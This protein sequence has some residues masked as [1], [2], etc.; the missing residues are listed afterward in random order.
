M[1][2]FFKSEDY[3]LDTSNF[4]S[5]LHDRVVGVFEEEIASYVGAKYACTVNSATSAIFLIFLNKNTEVSVPSMIPPVVLNAL[6]TSGNKIKFYDDTDWVGN[7]YILHT[8]S[9]FKVVDSAQK[10]DKNQFKKE[11]N[12]QDLMF[13][14]H[15]PTKPVGSC[16]GGTIVSDDYEKIQ[17]LKEFTMNGMSFSHNNWEREI[18]FPGFK[19]YMNSLQADIALR[20][21]KSLEKNNEKIRKIRELY[22]YEL[23]ISNI[24]NHLYR[25]DVNDNQRF[26]KKMHGEGLVC[27][28]HYKAQHENDIYVRYSKKFD[29]DDL[30]KSKLKSKTT[31]S[32]PFYPDLSE[33]QQYK[34]IEKIK[35]YNNEFPIQNI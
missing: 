31:A 33:A 13:F 23:G 5:L 11:C 1:I 28:I 4:S 12:P 25:I 2:P 20:N 9:N 21:L 30:K 27:G 15:Y 8:F 26:I 18:K 6:I 24:S 29:P 16:D 10:L 3:I 32:I 22:N 7:S 35:K 14:S 34:V 17:R 19:M